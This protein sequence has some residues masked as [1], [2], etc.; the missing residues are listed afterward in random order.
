M[1]RRAASEVLCSRLVVVFAPVQRHP[2]CRKEFERIKLRL[3]NPK[4]VRSRRRRR[5]PCATVRSVSQW[6][7]RRARPVC[8]LL[9]DHHAGKQARPNSAALL[10]DTRAQRVRA[11]DKK[12]KQLG[13]RTS[14]V[15]HRCAH[16]Q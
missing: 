4:K 7:T 3:L 1:P 5:R 12:N 13:N 14:V 11:G 9:R 6:R 16:T 10:Q 2:D 15:L 8:G